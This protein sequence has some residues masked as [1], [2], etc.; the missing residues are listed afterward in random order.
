MLASTVFSATV[1][2]VVGPYIVIG[3]GAMAGSGISLMQ[4]PKLGWLNALLFFM[5]ASTISLL[6]T[7]NLSLMLAGV[8][9]SL[10]AH[11]LFAPVSFGLG[12]LGSKWGAILEWVGA[13]FNKWV[14]LFI[15][16]RK[17]P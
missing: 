14:D 17:L 4:R 1:A 2:A 6:L 12:Y 8:F 7:V 9:S 13:K 11:W 5:G 16:S 15:E 10:Q 3:I